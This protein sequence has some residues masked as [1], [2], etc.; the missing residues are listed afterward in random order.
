MPEISRFYGIVIKMYYNDHAPP[1]F[2]AEYGNDEM[3]VEIGTLNVFAGRLPRRATGLVLDWAAMHQPELQHA[4]DQSRNVEPLD[5]I[6][7]LP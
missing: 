3:L 6:D 7:P 2:H 5:A 4:W 1:H